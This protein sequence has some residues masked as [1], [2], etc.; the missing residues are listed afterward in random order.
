VE[1]RA[2]D[3]TRV[4]TA[5]PVGGWCAL[6]AWFAFVWHTRVPLVGLADLGFHEL[7]HLICY[8]LPV[9]DLPTAAAGS[10]LQILVPL[11]SAAY[12]GAWRRDP[13]GLAAGL[14]WAAA[15]C[16]DVAV[17]V[18]DAPY[19]QLELIG[20]EHDWAYILGPEQLDRIEWASGLATALRLGGIVLLLVAVGIVIDAALRRSA[21]AHRAG[22]RTSRVDPWPSTSRTPCEDLLPRSTRS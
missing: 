10:A 21:P 8:V 3:R 13:F 12:F 17:Y 22:T 20:G 7:G 4:A 14:A 2:L 19:E 5:A 6:V 9:G 18:T 15:N 11:G 1:R 16:A